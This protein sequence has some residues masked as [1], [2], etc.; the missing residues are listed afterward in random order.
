M[1]LFSWLD[2]RLAFRSLQTRPGF[3]AVVVATLALGIGVTTAMFSLLD[4]AV[5]RSLPFERPDRLMV[6]WG[7]REPGRN[8]RGASIPEVADWRALNHTFSAVSVWDPISLNLRTD[9]EP[10][11]VQAERVNAGY[12]E[13]LGV[14]AALG[15][16]FGAEEDRVPD[17]NP[18]ALVSHAFWT[19]RLGGDRSVLSRSITLNDR[20]F[21]IIGVMP[22]GFAGLSFQAEVW[23]PVAMIS[24]DNSVAQLTQRGNR[25]L[26]AVGRLKDGVT[27]EAAQSDLTAV[28]AGLAQRFPD[29]NQDRSVQLFSLKENFLGTT[30]SLFTALFKAVLL[31]LLIACVNVMSLQLVRANAREREIALRLA[32]GGGGWALTRQLLLESLV[33]AGLGG[34]LGVLVA[35]WAIRLLAPLAPPGVLPPYATLGVD[36]RVLLFTL[37]ITLLVGVACGLTPLLRGR[38]SDLAGALRDGARAYSLGLGRLRRPGLQQGF[39]VAEVAL[40]L[41]LLAG[42][43]L[44]VRSLRRQLAV[45]PGFSAAGVTVARISLPRGRYHAAERSAFAARLAGRLAELPGV[46]AAALGTDLPLRSL[47]NAAYLVVDLPR[48]EPIRYFRHGVTPGF[49]T[50]LGIPIVAGRGPSEEDRADTP[51]VAVVSQSMARRFWGGQALGHRLRL[52]DASG[53]EVV[54]VGVA[55]KARFRDLTSDLDAARSEPDVYFPMT[56][57]TDAD[58]E[59]AVRARPGGSVAAGRLQQ[60]VAALDGSLPIFSVER[61]DAAL[62]RQ[63]ATPRFGSLVLAGFSAI[64]LGL[65]A[66]GI[67]GVVAFVV[68]LSRRE[69]AIRLAL[70]ADQRKVRRVVLGNGMVLVLAGIALGALGARLGGQLLASQLFGIGA[71]DPTTLAGVSLVVLLVALLASWLPARRAAAV[72]PQAVLK[73]Q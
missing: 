16:S 11:R 61:L 52:D 7:T 64:A 56:Q 47:S 14:R 13:L 73:E 26:A 54:V 45:A 32:L 19:T 36:G 34:A 12:F 58:L 1:T 22:E 39:V 23:I 41:M 27:R 21:R 31:V 33:L 30:A 63:T 70:G 3:S 38:R 25:W 17:A 37:G 4:A 51:R 2:L 59:I 43:G 60:E 69:I 9:R 68:G 65:A 5:L 42:A 62:D 48:A 44:M 35:H 10:L 29:T 40:A 66:I 6:L 28:A 49:F 72:E 57:V 15:R 24:V 8:V 20:S 71:A 18:V 53:P 50:T 55:G 67:Y 46:S